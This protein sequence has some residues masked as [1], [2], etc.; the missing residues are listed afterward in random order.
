MALRQQ[1]KANPTRQRRDRV[2]IA[3]MTGTR[4]WK[5]LLVVALCLL[6][7]FALLAKAKEDRPNI[8][9]I[10]ADDLG[11]SD[12]GPYGGEIE[13]P[14]LDRLAK[15]GL[16]YTQ[17]HNA[18]VCCP[19][20]A[21]LMT[22]LYPHAAGMGA[23]NHPN[24]KGPAYHGQLR[25]NTPTIAEA[26]RTAG[27]ATWMVGK[28]HLTWSDTI[29]EGPNGSW[30]LQ[31]GFER[32]YY[33]MEGTKDYFEPKWLF[34]GERE[35]KEF[36]KDFYY[37]RA[38]SGK[39]AD[40]IE[41]HDQV[42]PFLLYAAF[43]APHFPLQAPEE[44]ISKYRD[45]FKAGWDRLREERL[46]RQIASGLL[47]PDTQLSPRTPNVSEWDTLSATQQEQ[48]A[49]RMAVYAAQVDELDHAIGRMLRALEKSKQLD[50]TLII[51]LSDNGAASRGGVMGQGAFSDLNARGVLN[52][53][54]G[55]GWSNL[56]NTPFRRYK[57]ET[58]SGG[59]MAPLIV[60]WPKRIREAG[61]RRQAA[62]IM[63]VMPTCL[64]VANTKLPVEMNGRA[65]VPLTGRSL[66]STF[67]KNEPVSRDLFW[68][69]NGSRAVRSGDWKLVAL[70]KHSA[71]ELYDLKS[72]PTEVR[73]LAS[74]QPAKVKELE[75]M[76]DSWAKAQ[77]V[78]PLR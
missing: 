45:R 41:K 56:S 76:W 29:E 13:T 26:L 11:F 78:A 49:Q 6:G 12:V 69:Y 16:R 47:P 63:D 43:C 66:T 40:W 65:T 48:L 10:M 21:S 27:Y 38:L 14:N 70:N 33:T 1:D 34:D 50:N 5:C 23:M 18:S 53:T 74:G 60:H 62:H 75:A 54:Y 8:I 64:E 42:K 46:K 30:P 31:R 3:I 59:T 2:S 44:T 4:V 22:G 35:V 24:R 9:I 25:E 7:S 20:R 68:E 77:G 36:P 28:W 32:G 58:H 17:F 57:M 55:S 61:V 72:D 19:S 71:W 67:N 73:D 15:N 51:F 52:S 37:E 39:A